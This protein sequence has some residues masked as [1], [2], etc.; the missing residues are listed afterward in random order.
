MELCR[1]FEPESISSKI[2]K[3]L[4]LHP[5]RF[6]YLE[7]RWQGC[8]LHNQLSLSTEDLNGVA[9]FE[10]CIPTSRNYEETDGFSGDAV[11]AQAPELL[12]SRTRRHEAWIPHSTSQRT[13]GSQIKLL[14]RGASD[15]LKSPRDDQVIAVVSASLHQ[16]LFIQLCSE[17]TMLFGAC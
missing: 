5:W 2:F 1:P 14:V 6:V 3:L 11:R 8:V 13:A 17:K 16:I 9:M 10:A 4:G 7:G 12:P 15:G